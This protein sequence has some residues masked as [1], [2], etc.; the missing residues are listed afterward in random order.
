MSR[1]DPDFLYTAVDTA[2]CAIPASRDRRNFA[3][4]NS[5]QEIRDSPPRNR[6]QNIQELATFSSTPPPDM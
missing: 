6:W 4:A 3:N 5:P 1:D 2:A